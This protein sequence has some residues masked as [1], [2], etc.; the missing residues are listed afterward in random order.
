MRLIP[1]ITIVQVLLLASGGI[2][3]VSETTAAT[4]NDPIA[5]EN[6]YL[7]LAVGADGLTVQFLDKAT[8]QD[9]A[10]PAWHSRFLP[11]G[12]GPMCSR[13]PV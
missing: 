12:G 2:A 13:R 1:A 8:N 7:R 10:K 11:S 5:I 3:Q 6:D 4:A 9:Y